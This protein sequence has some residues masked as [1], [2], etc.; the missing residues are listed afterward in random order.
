MTL[1]IVS[2]GQ[3]VLVGLLLRDLAALRLD[4]V[5]I[6]LTLNVPEALPFEPDEF[7]LPVRILENARPRGFG[8]NH[9]AAFGAC[10]TPYFCI[11]NPDVRMDTNPFPA[12]IDELTRT[13]VAAVAPLVVNEQGQIEDSARRFP[14]VASLLR[15]AFKRTTQPDYQLTDGP[16]SPDWVAGMFVLFRSK[17]YRAVGGF[18]ERYFLY[19]EDVDICRRLRDAGWDIRM[20]PGVSVVHA[21]RRQSHGN[22]RYTRW[23]LRS[24]LR[25]LS[26]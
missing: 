10:A 24:M 1:S 4:R 5:E 8:A 11:L 14:T 9:N 22:L 23:H 7:G 17:A 20:V 25:F 12:L 26:S 18:D 3:A 13:D 21:A 16:V 15:K 19:Y 2:H 6:I